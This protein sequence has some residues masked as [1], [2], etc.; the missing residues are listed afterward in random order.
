MVDRTV[1]NHEPGL[2]R[3]NR[4]HRIPAASKGG[5]LTIDVAKLCIPVGMLRPL[6]LFPI[7][8]QRVAHLLQHPRYRLIAHRMSPPGQLR[9]LRAWH[10][11]CYDPVG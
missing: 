4:D 7:Q 11:R 3:V 1:H 9:S 5:L 2:I 8:L 6:F 10:D